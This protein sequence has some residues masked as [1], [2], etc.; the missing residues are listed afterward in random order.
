M[1][2]KELDGLEAKVQADLNGRVSGFRIRIDDRGLIILEGRATTYYTK[3]LA[4]HAVM[5][6]TA[7]PIA[8]NQITVS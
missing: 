4:Q 7:V 5:Q 8:A 6:R 1:E 2:P 3:Q